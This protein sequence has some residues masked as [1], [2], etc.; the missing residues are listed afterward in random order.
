MSIVH[1]RLP[2][3]GV[4]TVFSTIVVPLDGSETAAQALPVAKEMAQRFGSRMLF[5]QVVDTG[6]AS[7]ALGANAASGGM[8]DPA[9]ITGEVDARVE[10]AKSYL[11]AV[12]EEMTAA[13]IAAEYAIHDGPVAE[14]IISSAAEAEADLIVMCSHGHT[15]LRRL[16]FGSVADKVIRNAPMPVLIIRATD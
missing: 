12:V 15:G 13:D 14:D 1:C 11:S 4:S 5:V 6:S 9:S 3:N 16:V 8:A 7:L 10:V 2:A